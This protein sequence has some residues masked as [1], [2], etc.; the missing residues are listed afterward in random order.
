MKILF[1]GFRHDHIVG[2]YEKAKNNK[3]VEIVAC[4]EEH[5]QTRIEMQ[6]DYGIVF[7]TEKSYEEWLNSDV[8]IVA[9]SGA[10]GDRGEAA[11]KA[12]KKGKHL[13]LD[14]PICIKKAELAKIKKLAE[15]KNLKVQCMFDL[16]YLP[17]TRLAKKIISSGELGEV[18]NISYTGQH[19]LNY[20]VRPSW[21]FEK[22]KHGGTL[23]DL[24]IHGIDLIRFVTG[25]EFAKINAARVWNAFAKEEPDFK[26][27]ATY[28][29]T[30][31]NGAG[32]LA[33]VSYSSPSQ[34]YRTDS[35]WNFKFWCD[36]GL[37]TFN[38]NSDSVTIYDMGEDS[39]RIIKAEAD[40]KNYLDDLINDIISDEFAN[41]KSV[42]K[43]SETALK[44]Q[45][46]AN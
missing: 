26:D 22:G 28:M 8:E 38:I 27:C 9:L 10:Y 43:S 7:D 25:N 39:P 44:I 18:R 20:G 29:A 5:E 37:L 42:L 41:T 14:K 3:R 33:D 23:N 15:K 46:K 19:F 45:A 1:Y 17:T 40:G 16:R 24:A 32:V 30:L 6:R 2:L 36:K 4:V 21:Y 34:V 11:I 12:L 13:I 31:T 35:Y